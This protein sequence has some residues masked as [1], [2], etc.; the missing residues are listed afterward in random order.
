MTPKKIETEIK[1]FARKVFSISSGLSGL[2]RI[3]SKSPRLL[4]DL[5][6]NCFVAVYLVP[7]ISY[8][9][10]TKCEYVIFVL[11]LVPDLEEISTISAL[12]FSKLEYLIFCPTTTASRNNITIATMIVITFNWLLLALI[13]ITP[14]NYAKYVVQK[15][16]TY[17]L[18]ERKLLS[19]TFQLEDF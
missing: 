3:V 4:L 14:Y 18:S 8:S 6:K 17:H 15:M 7:S 12:A 2:Y 5:K 1:E 9:Y 11:E 13:L 19:D 10:L 16:V